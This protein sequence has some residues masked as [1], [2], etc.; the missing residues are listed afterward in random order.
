[1]AEAYCLVKMGRVNASKR[2]VCIDASTL[3]LSTLLTLLMIS[4]PDGIGKVK[5]FNNVPHGYF[6]LFF[7]EQSVLGKLTSLL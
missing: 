5:E 2:H 1:M 4:V 3:F 7:T 6:L